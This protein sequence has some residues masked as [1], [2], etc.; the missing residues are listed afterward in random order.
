MKKSQKGWRDKEGKEGR[1]G[2][3]GRGNEGNKEYGFLFFCGHYITEE[4]SLGFLPT[5]IY[6]TYKQRNP[7]QTSC[8]QKLSV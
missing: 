2:M 6:M 4:M 3:R 7:F 5:Y 1:R 8:L